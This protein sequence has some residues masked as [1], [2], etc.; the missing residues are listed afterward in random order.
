MITFLK[1][2]IALALFIYVGNVSFDSILTDME[3]YRQLA[4]PQI[5]ETPVDYGPPITA[6]FVAPGDHWAPAKGVERDEDMLMAEM[7]SLLTSR[8]ITSSDPFSAYSFVP[9]R[10][11]KCHE[12]DGPGPFFYGNETF[13]KDQLF[14]TPDGLVLRSWPLSG[15]APTLKYDFLVTHAKK[16]PFTVGGA[17]EQILKLSQ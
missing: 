15:M 7:D 13:T 4:T 1:L 6:T 16:I 2:V 17:G 8:R 3:R 14:A 5:G 9:T 10:C 12:K 11:M